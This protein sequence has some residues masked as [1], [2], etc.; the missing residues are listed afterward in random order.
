MSL[1]T[2]HLLLLR[3][4]SFY[5][6]PFARA[7]RSARAN[8]ACFFNWGFYCL[9]AAARPAHNSGHPD[10]ISLSF[11]QDRRLHRN[12]HKQSISHTCSH[13]HFV[14]CHRGLS[15]WP[16]SANSGS[17]VGVARRT[18]SIDWRLLS[19]VVSREL[20]RR[21]AIHH[22]QY[23]A[24]HRLFAHCLSGNI[25]AV[26][27]AE[28]IKETGCKCLR[29]RVLHLFRVRRASLESPKKNQQSRYCSAA[30]L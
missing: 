2:C 28:T 11:Q 8:G 16:A 10:C 3:N 18:T 9:L 25:F 26:A 19:Q 17:R 4:V 1:V 27:S 24:I 14:L 23:G 29:L 13:H 15:A 12:V 30:F 21:L 7:G 22:W 6:S 5:L 20:V